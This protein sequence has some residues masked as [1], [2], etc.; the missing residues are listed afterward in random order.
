MDQNKKINI[1]ALDGFR[2]LAII[3]VILYHLGFD[4]FKGGL[5]GVTMFFV[6]SGYLITGLLKNEIEV[7]SKINLKNFWARRARRLMPAVIAVIV[8]VAFLCIIL[9]HFLLT[10]MRPDIIP[11]IFFVQNWWYVFR[12]MSYFESLGDPSPLVHFWSLAIEEQFYLIWPLVLI[13]AYKR[14]ANNKIIRRICIALSVIS[15]LAMAIMFDPMDDPTRIYYGTDTWA[16]S[17]LLGAWLAYVFPWNNLD[18]RLEIFKKINTKVIDI[19]AGIAL[20]TII[21]FCIFIDGMSP[22]MYYGILALTSILTCVVLVALVLPDGKLAKLFAFKPFVWAGKRSYGMYLWHLPI[23]LI[24][25]G[26]FNTDTDQWWF[27]ILVF[28]LVFAICGIQYKYIEEP[29]RRGEVMPRLRALKEKKLKLSKKGYVAFGACAFVILLSVIGIFT[30]P[31]ET[32]VPQEALES[33]GV[34]E[35]HAP[36]TVLQILNPIMIGDSVPAA[37]K[38]EEMYPGSRNDSV[39]SRNTFQAVNVLQ[40]YENMGSVGNVVILSCFSNHAMHGDELESAYKIVGEQRHLFLINCCAPY[41]YCAM[42]N[43]AILAFAHEHENVHVIDWFGN[44][45]NNPDLYFYKDKIHLTPTGR[46]LYSQLIAE[47]LNPFLPQDLQCNPTTIPAL[48]P[49]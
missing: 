17:L 2:A 42:N 25:K 31:D 10:K 33:T 15:I 13:F 8:C 28:V 18:G 24:L 29:I 46:M 49:E 16:F 32:Y 11:S 45:M 37:I 39:V 7:S 35:N 48:Y 36:A 44:A 30:V 1:R 41:D 22:A 23:I 43:N 47:A 40:E 27:A 6:L 38:L 20:A 5:L 21:I 3:S 12:G 19:V 14:G 9:N 34:S 4:W 26:I